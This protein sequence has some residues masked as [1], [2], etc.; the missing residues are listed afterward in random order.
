M[1]LNFFWLYNIWENKIQTK[2]AIQQSKNKFYGS[3]IMIQY[4]TK[5]TNPLYQN[6]NAHK[7]KI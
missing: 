3:L 6:K 5:C 2:Y 1:K 7:Q 4:H